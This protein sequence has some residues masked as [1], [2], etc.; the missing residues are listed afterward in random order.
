MEN[1]T[2]QTKEKK[3]NLKNDV[4]FQT[5]FARKGNEEFLIDFLNALLNKNIQKIEI[6]EEVNLERLTREEKGGRL[7]LQAKLEDGTIV[8]IER[9]RKRIRHYHV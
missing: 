8:S 1:E 5:F 2:Q 6:R 7:D 9:Q 3:Y 4:I